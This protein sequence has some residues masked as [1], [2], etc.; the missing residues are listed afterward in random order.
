[1][2]A[3]ARVTGFQGE[4]L[5]DGTSLL[6]CPKHFAAYGGA[7]GGRDYNTVDLSER[8]L[9]EIYLP[10][11]AAAVRAGAATIMCSFNEI[12]GVPSSGNAHLLTDILRRQ[13]G[14]QGFV[15]SDWGSIAEM[16]QHS[17]ASTPEEA[18]LRAI[19]AGV[20][21]DM[22]GNAYRDRLKTLVVS[23][24][25]PPTVLDQAVRRV[26][27]AKMLLGLLDHPYRN[28]TPERERKEILT[29]AH[30]ALAR[31]SATKSFVLLKNEGNLLPLSKNLGTLAVIGPL[32][33]DRRNILGPWDAAGRPDDA[34]SVLEG[35]RTSV[36]RRM[37]IILAKGCQVSGTSRTL[38]PEAVEAVKQA[39]A[40][41]VV[42]GEESTMSGEAA[43]RSSLGLPGVQEELLTELARVGKPIV[44][45]LFNGRPLAIPGIHA[46][47]PAILE[48]WLSG[49]EGG[50]AIADVL[51]GE[52]AP[53]GKLPVTFPRSV[54]QIPL[55]YN[56]KNTGRPP[57]D[58]VK[59]TSKY[60]DGPND[61]LYPFG[62][63]LSY[64]RFQYGNLTLSSGTLRST[65]NFSAS[66]EL[67]NTGSRPGDEVVQL[68][69]RDLAGSFTRPVKE[70]KAFRRVA[71]RPGEKKIVTFDLTP[72]HLSML[73]AHFTPVVEPGIFEIMV[74]GNSRDVLSTPLNV[75]SE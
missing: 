13:W 11:F 36:G 69:V 30:R 74:G 71:L 68:Y 18:A 9:H 48:C 35:I 47:V 16:V 59:F 60:I 27:R 57:V 56:H 66:V 42:L 43:S 55:Y 53:S 10:P 8:T 73:D 39:D 24:K 32:A 64:T 21:M 75:I 65:Q 19:T 26:L 38:F 45:V 37:K 20:D 58:T 25:V 3:A 17:F 29:P 44:I 63:G 4:N 12:A 50:N 46:L 62:Y 51:F 22:E 52:R 40:A 61:P 28:A 34:V 33:D 6:A 2:M 67:T 54:G 31:E 15:V 41:V 70:L 49:V 23:G 1:V 5:H 72:E 14:F 7:E